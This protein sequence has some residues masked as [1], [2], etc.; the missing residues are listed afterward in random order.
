M[1]TLFFNHCPQAGF[2]LF[3][4]V[5]PRVERLDYLAIS[6]LDNGPLQFQSWRQGPVGDG[7]IVAE[8]GHCSDLGM[9]GKGVQFPVDPGQNLGVD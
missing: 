9:G 1:P 8:Q 3:R 2:P 5:M 7:P 6:L 4:D